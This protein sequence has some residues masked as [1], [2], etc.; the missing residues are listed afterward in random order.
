MKKKHAVP[1]ENVCVGYAPRWH[2]LTGASQRD[3]RFEPRESAH[4]AR[5]EHGKGQPGAWNKNGDRL[6]GALAEREKRREEE[7]GG[8]VTDEDAHTARTAW[9]HRRFWVACDDT[10]GIR[11]WLHGA[12]TTMPQPERA[13]RVWVVSHTAILSGGAW[14]AQEEDT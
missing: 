9:E 4:R 8:V 6:E 7:P 10:D 13:N 2:P 11:G 5:E 3:A 14:E 12:Q 1:M